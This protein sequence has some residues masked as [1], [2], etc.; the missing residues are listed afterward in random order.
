MWRWL[1]KGEVFPEYRKECDHF[2]HQLPKKVI[3]LL[4]VR[5]IMYS[6]E[7]RDQM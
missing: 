3:N 7:N 4:G 5:K 2:S 1:K 6:F